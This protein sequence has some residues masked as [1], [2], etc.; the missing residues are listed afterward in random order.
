MAKARPR[1]GP[2]ARAGPRATAPDP[3]RTSHAGVLARGVIAAL[4][5]AW[6]VATLWLAHGAVTHS[7][8]ADVA[9]ANAALTLPAVIFAS[10]VAGAAIAGAATRVGR[11]RGWRYRALV[12]CGIGLVVGGGAGALVLIGYGTADALMA[13]AVAIGLAAAIGGALSG[14]P[15][16]A[17]LTAGLTGAL[18]WCGVGLVDGIFNGTLQDIFASDSSPAAQLVAADRLSFVVALVGGA[19]GGVAGYLYLRK[20]DVSSRWPGYLAAGA[21]PGLFLL[22]TD[23]ATRIGGGRL[24]RLAASADAADEAALAYVGGV[25]LNTALIVLFTGSITTVVLFGRTLKPR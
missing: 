1:R 23:V 15:A 13:L 18:V 3:P 19:F 25:R 14:M 10:L 22:V 9:V 5:T 11:T 6:F 12:G 16:S 7:A 24:L 20:S 8:T 2:A 4:C 21:T 17:V